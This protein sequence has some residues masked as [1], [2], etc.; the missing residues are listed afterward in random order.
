MKYEEFEKLSPEEQKKFAAHSYQEGEVYNGVRNEFLKIYGNHPKI[1]QV[2]VD[3]YGMGDAPLIILTLNR[4]KEK[5]QLPKIF[6]G[7]SI[8]RRYISSGRKKYE[9]PQD[10]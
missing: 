9:H 5:L 4:A 7:F 10:K 2:L 3:N 6:M 1:E 8:Y